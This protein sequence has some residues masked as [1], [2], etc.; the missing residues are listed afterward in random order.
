MPHLRW[1]T[2]QRIDGGRSSTGE[3][4]NEPKLEPDE[5]V[6]Q[7]RGRDESEAADLEYLSDSNKPNQIDIDKSRDTKVEEDGRRLTQDDR[8]NKPTGQ[9]KV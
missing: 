2:D 6:E 1:R 5:L 8:A 9:V 4:N 7:G 3:E